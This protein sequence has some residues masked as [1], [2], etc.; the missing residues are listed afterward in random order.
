MNPVG[1]NCLKTSSIS[2]FEEGLSIFRTCPQV[3]FTE[4]HVLIFFNLD[5]H[6]RGSDVGVVPAKSVFFA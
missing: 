5:L 6:E 3:N 2:T 4:V 1:R